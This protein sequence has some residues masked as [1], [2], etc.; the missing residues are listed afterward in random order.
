MNARSLAVVVAALAA[1]GGEDAPV[2]EAPPLAPLVR[3]DTPGNNLMFNF[4]PSD[5]VET[6]ASPGGRFLIHFTRDGINAVP[7]TDSDT[8]GIPD[9]VEQVAQVYDQV[10]VHYQGL[11]L[12]AP[13]DDGDIAD[14]G[15]DDRF[16]VYLVDFN[17]IGDGNYRNDACGPTNQEVCAGYMI[18]EN[19]YAGYGYPSTLVA[20]RILGSHEFFHAIQA[21]YDNNQGSVLAEGTAV[22]GTE[23]FDEGLNDFEAFIDGYLNNADRP[24]DQPL[25]GPVDPFSYGSAIF[26]QFVEEAYG[27]GIVRAILESSENGVG[28]VADPIWF[29]QLDATLST[30]AQSPFADVFHEFVTWNLYTT[31]AFADPAQA[32]ANGA[33]YP[34]VRIDMVTAPHQDDSL[35]VYYASAHY[36]GAAPLGRPA[37]TAAVVPPA[38]DA[39]AAEG[40]EMMLVTETSSGI[41]T[42]L[43]IADPTAGTETVDTNGVERV[44]TVVFNPTMGGESKKPGLCIG[45]PE[46]V[47]SCKEQLGGAGGAGGGGGGGAPPNDDP[48]S[49]DDGDGGCSCRVAATKTNTPALLCALFFYFLRR[50]RAATQANAKIA[51]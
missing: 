3:P 49:D 14:N 34:R 27:P 11:G 17:G 19:D 42:V 47:Q 36:F 44:V 12:R 50:R 31:S 28:G 39:A 24:L 25:P 29:E 18:Q 32:Y 26:F 45:S 37:M 4:E 48:P 1:C 6:H 46:E 8:S 9:F 7:D 13:L 35:R 51:A 22:W 38:T 21:A 2:L 40:L 30:A 23:S 20:N 16:D 15:G 43:E 5:V 10:L 41:G 33:G